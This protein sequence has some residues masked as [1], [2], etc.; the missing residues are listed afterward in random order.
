[1]GVL[2]VPAEVRAILLDIEGTTTPIAFVQVRPVPRPGTRPGRKRRR[3]YCDPS[4]AG[5]AGGTLPRA[6]LGARKSPGLGCASPVPRAGRSVLQTR[7]TR[8]RS[9]CFAE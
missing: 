5:G 6:D 3:Y 1:M 8:T 4:A 9:M 7:K 2:P